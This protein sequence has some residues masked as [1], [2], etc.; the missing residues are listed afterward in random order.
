MVT[1]VIG[2]SVVHKSSDTSALES[3][4]QSNS[5]SRFHIDEYFSSVHVHD[6]YQSIESADSIDARSPNVCGT[7][8]SIPYLQITASSFRTSGSKLKTRRQ[9]WA[10][11]TK[12]GI[13]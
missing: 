6:Q 13:S 4:S 1:S 11:N 5:L 3:Q 8:L 9:F 12:E 10:R 2:G 7:V